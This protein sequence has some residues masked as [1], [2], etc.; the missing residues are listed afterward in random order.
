MHSFIASEMPLGRKHKTEQTKTEPGISGF[1]TGKWA[2][3]A[4][5][6][7]SFDEQHEVIVPALLIIYFARE[8]TL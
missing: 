7:Y 4:K 8:G 2:A 5:G 6:L 3:D 1:L